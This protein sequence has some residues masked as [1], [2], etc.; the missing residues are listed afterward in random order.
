MPPKQ[1][2]TKDTVLEAALDIIREQGADALNA[3]NLAKQ[4]GTST[5]PV[6]SHFATMEE[7]KDAAYAHAEQLYNTA[8]LNGLQNSKDGFLGMGLA[9]IQFART[10]KNLFQL[11]FMSNKLEQENASE[12]AGSTEGDGQVIAMISSMTGL[13]PAQAQ[14]LY[15]ALWFT[16]HGIASLLATNGTKLEDDEAKGLL[17][18]VFKG[19]IHTLKQEREDA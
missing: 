9:Y 2:I 3:R 14:K 10:E 13:T 5:Q 12:I 15:T 17:G 4:L 18:L 16:T 6:F 1:K 8:M 11:L 19:M 7:L